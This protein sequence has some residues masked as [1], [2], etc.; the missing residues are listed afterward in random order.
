MGS[1]PYIEGCVRR[2]EV[3][4][5][6]LALFTYLSMRR[7]LT[8]VE[9]NRQARLT[10][11]AAA[12]ELVAATKTVTAASRD[13]VSMGMRVLCSPSAPPNAKQGRQGIRESKV[14]HRVP[15]ANPTVQSGQCLGRG[16]AS[17]IYQLR[18]KSDRKRDRQV[19]GVPL[20][21]TAIQ[22]W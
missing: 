21:A 11:N 6:E 12:R 2:Q 10:T 8:P 22:P 9:K 17:E 18:A 3:E 14:K 5:G 20:V 1:T 7:S 16:F 15:V 4:S 13:P 19:L